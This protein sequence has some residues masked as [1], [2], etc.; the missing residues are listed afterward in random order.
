MVRGRVSQ[1]TVSAG[2]ELEIVGLAS[3]LKAK[4]TGIEMFNKVLAR[5]EAGDNIGLQLGD[6]PAEGIV[7][8]M[9]VARPGSILPHTKFGAL[10]YVLRKEEG[11]RTSPVPNGYAPRFYLRTADVPGVMK[12]ADGSAS[13][14]LGDDVEV[15]IE[16]VS[17]V[18]MDPGL[19]FAIREGGRTVGVGVVTR[20][21]E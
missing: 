2:D 15:E 13:A 19:H 18:A 21:I 4:V 16:L 6:V 11:G 7:P 20:V 12:L 1:G 8:G 9:V 3:A 5:A 17:P 14:Q 10:V